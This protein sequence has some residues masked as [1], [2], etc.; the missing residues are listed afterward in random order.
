M[1]NNG[2]GTNVDDS[3]KG[4]EKGFWFKLDKHYKNVATLI[5]KHKFIS[6][7]I[8]TYLVISLMNSCVSNSTKN[9]EVPFEYSVIHS[10]LDSIKNNLKDPDSLVLMKL[11][12]TET[13]EEVFGCLTY[14]AKNSFNAYIQGNALIAGRKSD[15]RF[16]TK[17]EGSDSFDAMWEESCEN[18]SYRYFDK[19]NYYK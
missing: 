7:C 1:E 16:F 11:Y 3:T 19:T 17:T 5:G 10:G 4:C 2:N 6:F 12:I 15:K 13:N 8:M 14:K 18:K 9:Y